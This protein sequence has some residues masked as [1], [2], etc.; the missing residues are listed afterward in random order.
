MIEVENKGKKNSDDVRVIIAFPIILLIIWI[1]FFTMTVI[2]SQMSLM[3]LMI[4]AFVL[5]FVYL[6]FNY[7]VN[8]S[9]TRCFSVMI[10]DEV[11]KYSNSKF[12]KVIDLS[13][14]KGIMLLTQNDFSGSTDYLVFRCNGY[15]N[16][17][18]V[19]NYKSKGTDLK[20]FAENEIF[21]NYKVKKVQN[22][23]LSQL[24]S[25]IMLTFI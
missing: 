24:V 22:S 18:V 1:L 19:S 15:R 17:F 5:L 25:F 21:S 10:E 7:L 4:F 12:E 6:F 20:M 9:R 14:L 13:S 16:S 11:I 23:F 3:V 8:L 2:N